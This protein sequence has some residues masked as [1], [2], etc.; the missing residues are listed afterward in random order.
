MRKY[1]SIGTSATLAA[2]FT[3]GLVFSAMD[4]NEPLSIWTYQGFFRHL[5]LATERL[6]SFAHGW[7]PMSHIRD[8]GRFYAPAVHLICPLIGFLLFWVMSRHKVGINLWK[9]MAIALLLTVPSSLLTQ[10]PAYSLPWIEV[11]RTLL[12]VWLMVRSVGGIRGIRSHSPIAE[13]PATA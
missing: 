3:H 7:Q 1:L 5:L 6:W 12:I 2:V 8:F 4:L 13:S 10:M 9:P 11:A